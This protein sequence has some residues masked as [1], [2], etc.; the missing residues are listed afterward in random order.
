V[1]AELSLD[2]VL[3]KR[4]DAAQFALRPVEPVPRRDLDRPR[5]SAAA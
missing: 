4:R 5:L 1:P 2:L 3:F